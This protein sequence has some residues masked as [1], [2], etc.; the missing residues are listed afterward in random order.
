MDIMKS[1]YQERRYIHLKKYNKLVRDR[2]PEV[3]EKDGHKAKFKTLSE[4]AYLEA[5]DKKLMEEVKEYQA[6]KSIEEMA[7]VLEVLYAICKARGYTLD[8]VEAKRQEKH[9]ERGGFEKRLFL[10]YVEDDEESQTGTISDMIALK[11][12]SSIPDDLKEALLSNVFCANCGVTSIF[13]YAIVRDKYGIVLQGKCAK[14][15]DSVAR[16]VED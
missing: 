9:I 8:E 2:I 13:D 5:L 16:Y 10:E 7:D 1:G 4:K 6:D 3:I 11:K 15:G 14:C 12:W